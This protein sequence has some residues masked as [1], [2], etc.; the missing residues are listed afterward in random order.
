[1]KIAVLDLGTNTFNLIIAEKNNGTLEFCEE[2]K[3]PVKIGLSA[4]KHNLIQPD[5]IQRAEDTAR[6]YKNILDENAVEKFKVYATSGFRDTSNGA[7][8]KLRLQQIL[9]TEIEIIDGLREAELIYKGVRK[10]YSCEKP[11]L[12]MDIGGGSVEFIIGHQHIIH[13][14]HSLKAGVAKLNDLF[15]PSDPIKENEISAIKKYFHHLLQ[16]VKVKSHQY[17]V[18][19]LCGASGVF[20]TIANILH[21]KKHGCELPPHLLSYPIPIDALTSLYNDLKTRPLAERLRIPGMHE[22]RADW[23]VLS[24]IQI[25]TTIELCNI[26]ELHAVFYSLKEGALFEMIDPMA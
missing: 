11:F 3:L 4:F 6:F 15:S 23:I 7:E 2:Y 22:M 20:E 10:A 14:L 21:Y 8:L 1:M 19:T 17:A 5:A 26:S 9:G 16:D 18:H 12:I 13:S 25:L 24:L